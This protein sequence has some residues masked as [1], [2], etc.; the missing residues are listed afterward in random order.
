MSYM[1]IVVIGAVA[2]WLAGQYFK[3]SEAGI[4]IDF[5]AGAIGA[6]VFVVISR[7]VSDGASGMLMSVL[8][9]IAG[10]TLALYGMRRYMKAQLV[11]APRARRRS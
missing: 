10:A 4:G 9:A 7:V 1:F 5:L 6:V 2:G 8:V 11:P 3:G